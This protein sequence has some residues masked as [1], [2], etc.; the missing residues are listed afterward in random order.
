MFWNTVTG[1]VIGTS[2]AAIAYLVTGKNH[3]LDEP[4][5][6]SSPSST[7]VGG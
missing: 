1:A 2:V 7:D 6:F 4:P 3:A 5:T